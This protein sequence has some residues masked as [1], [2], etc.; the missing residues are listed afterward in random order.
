MIRL[1]ILASILVVVTGCD[2]LKGAVGGAGDGSPGRTVET[3]DLSSKPD[4]LFQVFG[5][6]ADTRILPLAA[7]IDGTVR[8]IEL[9]PDGWR[10]FASIYQKKGTEYRLY[11]YGR[12]VGSLTIR[13]G[14]WD[15]PDAPVYSLPNCTALL[16]LAAVKLETSLDL[17]FTVELL[18]TS[19]RIPGRPASPPMAAADIRR[20][21]R[22][23]GYR[24]GDAEGISRKALDG[25]QLHAY[26]VNSGATAKPT[27]VASFMDRGDADGAQTLG[28]VFVVA[29]VG[30]DGGYAPTFSHAFSGS[31]SNA[32]YRVYLNHL[33][34]TGDGVQEIIVEAR[35]TSGGTYVVVLGYREGAWHEI[36][37][38]RPDWCLDNADR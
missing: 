14:M 28:H 3:L 24:V 16:P 36:F 5:E 1:G 23:M 20:I 12:D 11:D 18:A 26:G 35:L 9:T 2:K 33:D 32:Q 25:L 4:I 22:E 19:A 21:A 13:Q 8:P 27:I 34:L 38:S 7:L 29:D 6:R 10:Q 15:K 30:A 17:G 31:T 37:Q